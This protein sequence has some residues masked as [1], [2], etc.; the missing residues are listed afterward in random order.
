MLVIDNGDGTTL[1]EGLVGKLVAVKRF[2]FQGNENTAL[3]TLA[4]IG[5]DDRM[6]LVDFV[7]FFAVHILFF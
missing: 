7:K 5:S 4:A 1:V 3:R 6:L 2:A